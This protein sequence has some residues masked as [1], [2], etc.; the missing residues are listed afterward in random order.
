MCAGK[1]GI[2]PRASATGCRGLRDQGQEL[3]RRRA[4]GRRFPWR[5]RARQR[6]D[7]ATNPSLTEEGIGGF[8][9]AQPK[10]R[11][12]TEDPPHRTA[13]VVPQ[14][15][16][17]DQCDDG[18]APTHP[19][20]AASQRRAARCKLKRGRRSAGRVG[21]NVPR[22]QRACMALIPDAEQG[23]CGTSAE[24]NDAGAGAAHGVPAGLLSWPRSVRCTA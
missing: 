2:E 20:Q 13:F 12:S 15:G 4:P 7:P 23:A 9:E 24:R 5:G 6:R 11:H 21:T 3:S 16:G 18:L 17:G 10:A 14:D 8:R 1:E 19:S 22:Q